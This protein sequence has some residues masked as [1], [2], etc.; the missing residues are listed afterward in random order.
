M[1]RTF[2]HKIGLVSVFCIAITALALHMPM[3]C[4]G[5]DFTLTVEFSPNII[6]I[7]SIR[8][9]D[10]RILTNMRYSTYVADGDSIFIYFNE[11]PDSVQEIRATRDSL[12][13]LI[14]RFA[15]E[16]L[17][18]RQGDLN[19]DSGFNDAE[20]VIVMS[21]GV[22]YSATDEIFINANQAEIAPNPKK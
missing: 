19:T 20:V 14:L 15:M 1:N 21:S 3:P 18:D 12:G 11:S 13:N 5:E 10:I 17:L 9:G 22:E 7:E 8:L 6:N 2:G 16:H 4:Q